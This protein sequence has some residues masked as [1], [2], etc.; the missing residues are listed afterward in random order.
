MTRPRTRSVSLQVG[1]LST[2]QHEQ[3][4]SAKSSFVNDA[5]SNTERP[6]KEA[7][8]EG[9]NLSNEKMLDSDDRDYQESDLNSSPIKRIPIN[10]SLPPQIHDTDNAFSSS[11]I[12]KK[13]TVAFSDDL[14]LDTP[15][16]P[17]NNLTPM[18]S[19]LKPHSLNTDPISKNIHKTLS[20]SHNFEKYN[21]S[22]ENFWIA[23]SII[24][25]APGSPELTELVE[26]CIRVLYLANFEKRF[27]VYA[28]LNNILR[29][30]TKETLLKLFT[31]SS[32]TLKNS[33]K[34]VQINKTTNV[35]LTNISKLAYIIQQ[36]IKRL[37]DEL[38]GDLK[39]DSENKSQFTRTD[40]F[41][42]RIIS[43]AMKLMNFLLVD[44]DLNNFVAL[45]SIK[46]FY[47]HCCTMITKQTISKALIS[48]YLL[49]IK[50]CRLGNK[51]KKAVFENSALP[52]KI[53]QS[54]IL[55]KW[56]PSASV[57]T[58]KFTA[59]R[60]LII[61]FPGMMAKNI[62]HWFHILLFNVATNTSP[63]YM[64]AT[65]VG[66]QALLE[67]ARNYLDSKNILIAVRLLLDS[68]IPTKIKSFITDD[69]LEDIGNSKDTSTI[70]HLIHSL[71]ILIQSG[72]YKHAMDIWVA[73]TL[74]SADKDNGFETWKFLPQWLKVHKSC[75]NIQDNEAKLIAL[76]S[77]KA[78]VYNICHED[79]GNLRKVVEPMSN[80]LSKKI[81]QPSI[82]NTL[83]PKIKLLIH[84]LLNVTAIESQNEIIEV[85][86]DIFLSIVYTLLN[87]LSF[88][89]STKYIH[90]YWDK[91][92]QPVLHNFYFKKDSSTIY[93]NELG[94]KFLT[95]LLK[96]FMP[97]SERNYN[98][99][100]CLAN[101]PVTLAE[102]NSIPSRWVY[103]KFEKVLQILIL[104]FQLKLDDDQ[105]MNYFFLFLDNI[106]IFTK[107]EI[108]PSST[109][110]E[111][112]ESLP[113][114]IN[115]YFKNTEILN[116]YEDTLKIIDSLHNTFEPSLMV[117]DIVEGQSRVD[118]NVYLVIVRYLM[119]KL[120]SHKTI[121]L[122]NTILSAVDDKKY[123]I[124]LS[125]IIDLE[126]VTTSQNIL[127][128]I[129]SNF[130]ARY[131]DLSSSEYLICRDICRVAESDF[132]VLVKKLLQGI[133][134]ISNV[135]LKIRSMDLIDVKSW[136][137][138]T[139][140]YYL[141]LIK[142][143]PSEDLHEYSKK[144]LLERFQKIEEFSEI[145]K[146]LVV[147][148]FDSYLF[149]L[150]DTIL[151]KSQK[152]EGFHKFDFSQ[153]WKDFIGRVIK[154][155]DYSRID[156]LLYLT[157]KESGVEI[158]SFIR[159]KWDHLPLLKTEWLKNNGNLYYD[160]LLKQH[161]NEVDPPVVAN[162]MKSPENYAVAEPAGSTMNESFIPKKEINLNTSDETLEN[163]SPIPIEA[164]ISNHTVD[165]EAGKVKDKNNKDS[166][167]PAAKGRGKRRTRKMKE[168]LG[169]S[170]NNDSLTVSNVESQKR[171]EIMGFDIHSFT[172]LLTQKLSTPS[173]P[174]KSGRRKRQNKAS[175]EIQPTSSVDKNDN[176]TS[177]GAPPD[178]PTK[179]NN[180][181]VVDTIKDE[182]S[183]DSKLDVPKEVA[184]LKYNYS[185][186]MQNGFENEESRISCE[187]SPNISKRSSPE[188]ATEKSN[189]RQKIV[190][191]DYNAEIKSE[192]GKTVSSPISDILML[193]ENFSNGS[194]EIDIKT[195]VSN[196]QE[197]DNTFI[198]VPSFQH[199]QKS[200]AI[201]S[202]HNKT[203]EES[204]HIELDISETASS[205]HISNSN[206]NDGKQ[207]TDNSISNF[208]FTQ[209]NEINT[210]TN[211]IVQS[212]AQEA[213][214][215]N[216]EDHT[217]RQE[218]DLQIMKDE[219]N[220]H[221]DNGA[222]ITK[223]SSI[224]MFRKQL[225]E[226]SDEDLASMNVEEK[227]SLE[228]S[229][230]KFM[231]R[232]RNSSYSMS[233][234][235]SPKFYD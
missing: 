69:D 33:P 70:G 85:L 162:D 175:L 125:G 195:H 190:L 61:N 232:M 233:A 7:Y 227:H 26:G 167:V 172:A 199:A 122:M 77:W 129:L 9:G 72:H 221:I 170:D 19:I 28:T 196:P 123:N 32:S 197:L 211:P 42:I 189:K 171:N 216:N 96:T 202:E 93:M 218:I 135:E 217:I 100:R 14:L 187:V 10:F 40:P 12:K 74:L 18:K 191:N 20:N 41:R 16:S 84:I 222:P 124:L 116:P 131:P 37:E 38:F 102:I 149:S 113:Y 83:R 143:A 52:E 66:A 71:E 108:K 188:A 231:L 27:E 219:C 86:N 65:S 213:S 121:Q 226:I 54:V 4:I 126:M 97:I 147:H 11:P 29:S 6:I 79:L 64:K 120:D 180:S 150:K 139:F 148:S 235:Q 5:L 204:P 115:T 159:N 76:N 55:M 118:D 51:R 179:L 141:L 168:S 57:I 178:T 23:G 132:E 67:A 89:S 158:S 104:V 138:P 166:K 208:P 220:E 153:S 182:V 50:D 56:F 43:Q 134:T 75:F 59:L 111:I 101:D 210:G 214:L 186:I 146:Y 35:E 63:I 91:I 68:P 92:I 169:S 3:E 30:N 164:D 225:D 39:E 198:N 15:S 94:L 98:E 99:L 17:G 223:I 48:S 107:K 156:D 110:F 49:L 193:D 161:E 8:V 105:K 36:D 140:F 173:P 157:Y 117:P 230:L 25:L 119:P 1:L 203:N 112:I 81:K 212:D 206:S 46:W 78:I 229:M 73:V 201:E 114:I 90:V 22:D 128:A 163:I 62:I 95:R 24:Q 130:T 184:I 82:N 152:L 127:K 192:D 205:Q 80:S 155:E 154:S 224:A 133:V 45:E 207:S 144:I 151:S 58:E 176:A 109:T 88:K 60:N 200:M 215:V 142:D 103:L 185:E 174:K 177:V 53:L 31:I 2:K 209:Y 228:T 194:L 106:K 13:K 137:M 21:P 145:I 87:P 181:I 160:E 47:E 183:F 44:S 34:H 136:T 234:N 165:Q